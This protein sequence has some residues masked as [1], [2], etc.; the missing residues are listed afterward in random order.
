MLSVRAFVLLALMFATM[1]MCHAHKTKTK[2]YMFDPKTAGGVNGFI[3]VRYVYRHT[4][5]VGAVIA[6][7][8]DVKKAH[9]DALQKVDGNCTGPISEFRWHIHTKWDMPGTS[10]F[11]GECS[12]AK[13]GNHYDSDYACG[14]ASEHVTEDKCKAVTPNYACTPKGYKA[15]PKSC[16]KGDLSGKLG[17][18]KAKKG[19]IRGKWFDRHY[20]EP[21]ESASGWNML[22]H[23]VCGNNAPRY[24]CAKAV[25]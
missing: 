14:P 9:W 25:K 10:G 15:N 8:L 2:T 11:L 19:K 6:A 20:P 21:S 3:E 18:L 24:V 1:A 17:S 4:K 7:N 13:T 5:Y 22:I 12:L 23:A 16:E